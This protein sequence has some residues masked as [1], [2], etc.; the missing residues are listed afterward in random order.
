MGAINSDAQFYYRK[1]GRSPLVDISNENYRNEPAEA[2]LERVQWN[3]VVLGMI[4]FGMAIVSDE[5]KD[6][7]SQYL[8]HVFDAVE[9][10]IGAFVSADRGAARRVI[11]RQT[12]MGH[13]K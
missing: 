1:V 5:A 2:G 8:T 6:S 10:A 13:A 11:P 9:S 7:L 4:L 3:R 12:G